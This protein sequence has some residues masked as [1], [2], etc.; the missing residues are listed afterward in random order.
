M[1]LVSVYDNSDSLS[2]HITLTLLP[3]P[4]VISVFTVC[5]SNF[6]TGMFIGSRGREVKLKEFCSVVVFSSVTITRR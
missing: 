5:Q 2:N 3:M 6:Y 1:S 4:E